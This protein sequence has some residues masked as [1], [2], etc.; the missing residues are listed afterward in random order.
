MYG[1]RHSFGRIKQ[2]VVHSHARHVPSA[3]HRLIRSSFV[4]RRITQRAKHE[5][6]YTPRED[7]ATM[8]SFH[9]DIC[10]RQHVGWD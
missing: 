3:S 1:I 8:A 10:A 6:C 4:Q 2:F 5:G 9:R 7:E